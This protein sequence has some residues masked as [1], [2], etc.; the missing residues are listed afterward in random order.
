MPTRPVVSLRVSGNRGHLFYFRKMVDFPDRSVRPGALVDVVDREGQAVGV[1]FWNP[2][3]EIAIRIL[4][5][6]REVP[7]TVVADRLHA[8]VRLRHDVLGLP[9]VTDAY[10]VCHAEGDGLTGLVVD[11]FGGVI[12]AQLFSGGWLEN[13]A[14]LRDALAREFPGTAL[15]VTADDRVQKQEGFTLPPAHS[16]APVVVTEHHC[17]CHRAACRA[18]VRSRG[19]HRH[20]PQGDRAYRAASRYHQL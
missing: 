10:R 11:R 18:V 20:R 8:A 16:P 6:G 7:A 13:A 9:A 4:A 1:G 17:H 15:H 2:H 12:V 3:S 19:H 5:A 14:L